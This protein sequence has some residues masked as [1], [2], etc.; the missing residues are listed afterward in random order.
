[1]LRMIRT[2]RTRD[3]VPVGTPER[4]RRRGRAVLLLAGLVAAAGAALVVLRRQQAPQ[5]DPWAVPAANDPAGNDPT[6]E[7]QIEPVE[8]P[9]AD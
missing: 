7:Q 9:T 2:R 5:D 8:E 3:D 6:A 4:V 1:M